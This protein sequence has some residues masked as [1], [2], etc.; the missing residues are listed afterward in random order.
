MLRKIARSVARH[1]I[2]QMV[3]TS[4]FGKYSP[5]TVLVKDKRTGR[6]SY[7]DVQKSYFARSW[8]SYVVN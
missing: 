4:I 7:R 8:R 5:K 2:A 3:D 1:N 6:Y